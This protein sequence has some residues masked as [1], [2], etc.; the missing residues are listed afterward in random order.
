M[1]THS[2]ILD[3]ENPMDRGAQRAS[4]HR[5]TQSR[6]RLSNWAYTNLSQKLS[7]IPSLNRRQGFI[8]FWPHRTTCGILVPWPENKPIPLALEARSLN[9]W[10]TREVPEARVL[11]NSLPTSLPLGV[12]PQVQ[13]SQAQVPCES[14]GHLPS[15][16]WVW[17]VASEQQTCPLGSSALLWGLH[18]WRRGA[19]CRIDCLLLQESPLL[20]W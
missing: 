13:P 18:H 19:G 7:S 16:L 10:T 8:L 15:W 20:S 9:Q 17:N 2:S 6:T 5:V 12:F 14:V 1:A 3:W 4:V 11:K